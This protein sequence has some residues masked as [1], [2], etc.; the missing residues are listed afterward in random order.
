[1]FPVDCQL[2]SPLL[3]KRVAVLRMRDQASGTADLLRH[4]GAVPL[5]YPVI[6]LADPLEPEALNAVLGSLADYDVVV[7]TSTNGVERA[8]ARLRDLGLDAS[9]F[10]SSRVAAIGEAT[11]RCLGAFGVSADVTPQEYR[12]EALARSVLDLLGQA[13]GSKTHVPKTG[14]HRVLVIRALEAREVLPQV[15]RDAGVVVDVVAAYRTVSPPARELEE[16]TD[17][18]HR[19]VVDAVMLTSSSTVSGV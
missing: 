11:A 9:A 16:F 3:G 6:Q 10:G 13:R 2:E 4:H 14:R 19:G 7:F 5:V 15:L 1:M 18:L 12:G 17:L 8:F